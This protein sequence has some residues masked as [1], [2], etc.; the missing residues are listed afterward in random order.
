LFL[1]KK[2][3]EWFY[4]AYTPEFLSTLAYYYWTNLYAA[5]PAGEPAWW[6]SHDDVEWKQWAVFGDFTYDLTEKWILSVGARY[7]DSESE[8]VYEVD[9]RFISAPGTWPDRAPDAG[10]RKSDD[11]D[12][13]PKISLTYKFDE[14][15][16]VYGLFS[17][18]FR[19]GGVNRN[20]R[21]SP[22]EEYD[23]DTLSNYEIG[24][25][26]R[27]LDGRLQVNAT[28]FYMEWKDFQTELVDPAFGTNTCDNDGDGQ[29]DEACPFQIVVFNAGDAEQKGVELSIS[30][31][32]GDNLD[33]GLDATFLNAELSNGLVLDP[34]RPPVPEGSDLPSVPDLKY[35][36]YAQYNWPVNFVSGGSMYA[37]LQYS[38]VDDMINQLEPFPEEAP[39][40]YPNT[41]QR[42]MDSYGI[43]DFSLG[44]SAGQWQLQAFVDNL[45]DEDAELYWSTDN[46]HS[47][48]GRNQ[49]FTNRPREYGL[50]FL[51]R[52]G[53]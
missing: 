47:F 29:F 40:V 41:P 21:P 46:H 20:R 14:E 30:G 24:T 10:K 2:E 9:K 33:L 35:S 22:N 23:S 11:N 53:E 42:T 38:Y 7:F 36:V 28:A 51:Y 16:L 3:Q 49:L 25:K 27:W 18:G 13:L 52:W 1:E 12:I 5:N 15:K 43:A 26:T 8:R 6:F 31:I 19:A 39:G 44:L 4:R 32:I 34:G 50:R 37:R 17:Q 45:T 48:W